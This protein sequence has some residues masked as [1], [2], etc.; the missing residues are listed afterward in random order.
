[1]NSRLASHGAMY[2]DEW[3]SSDGMTAEIMSQKHEWQENIHSHTVNIDFILL[4]QLPQT[5]QALSRIYHLHG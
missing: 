1:M 2:S 4:H 5:G 3:L